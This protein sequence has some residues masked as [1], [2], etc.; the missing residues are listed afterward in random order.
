MTALTTGMR[1]AF[2]MGV[3]TGAML[4]AETF[5]AAGPEPFTIAILPDTQ[6]YAE[7][8]PAIF[9]SQ[10]QWIADNAVLEN[11][12]FVLHEG[13]IT[14]D[15][16]AGQWTNA[17][18]SLSVLD[19]M[20]P[21]ALALGNH[22]LGTNGSADTRDS[23]LFNT[24]FPVSR[25]SSLPT[26]GGV[27]EAGKLDNSFHLFT[28][29]GADWLVLALEFGPRDGVLAWANEV[30]SYFRSRR[31]IVVTHAYMYSDDTLHGSLPTH[32][33]NPHAYGVAGGPGGVND[34]V[35]MWDKFV[36]LH[37]NVRFVFNGH[38]L[39]DGVGT[40]VG[41]GAGGNKVY[42][43]LANYQTLPN[44]GNGYLRLVTFTPDTGQV[45]VRTYSP[46]L[47]QY[48]TTAANE[49]EFTGVDLGPLSPSGNMAPWVEVAGL[50]ALSLPADLAITG[51]LID[52][53]LPSGSVTVLWSK[54]SG[55]GAVVFGDERQ[56]GTTATFAQPGIYVLRLEAD[57]GSLSSSADLAVVVSL[58]GSLLDGLVGEWRFE[59]AAG[60]VALDSSGS[61]NDG[62]V[63]GASRVQGKTGS[64]LGLDGLDDYV[65]LS[66]VADD[67]TSGVTITAWIRAQAGYTSGTRKGIV[68]AVNTG[69]GGNVV[70][71]SIGDQTLPAND[72]EFMVYDGVSSAW[73]GVSD[74]VVADGTWHHV[75]YA[76]DGSTGRLYV[77]GLEKASHQVDYAFSPDDR[78]FL[79][80][81]LD[82]GTRGDFLEGTI[83]E[84][85]VYNR[86]L[87]MG[88]L[89]ALIS[90]VP[91]TVDAGADLSALPGAP[92][93]LDGTVSGGGPF[94]TGWM[95]LSGPGAVSFADPS[96]VDTMATF[97]AEGVYVLRLLAT[98]GRYVGSDDVRV[99]VTAARRDNGG[100]CSPSSHRGPRPR[101]GEG[102]LGVGLLVLLVASAVLGVPL[103]KRKTVLSAP[104]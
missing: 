60:S 55:P 70:L 45:S 74:T 73:E 66:S 82:G 31:V 83:D 13:D 29:G 49:F 56:L 86:A 36:R 2:A 80:Q 93:S 44:G 24:Y 71:L 77:D 62:S 50:A 91:P 10:T 72:D 57:D 40:L 33:W 41:T 6:V 100:G 63:V 51:T 22:D 52:D 103:K 85:R 32:K 88:E 84:V 8:F 67:V 23:T 89:Q 11:I 75:A 5:G 92:V 28:A 54:V 3:A 87:D 96:A 16:V 46:S 97:A 78:W 35:E 4:V 98:D 14:D 81:E 1:A 26:F 48:D 39:N 21:Y 61:G 7:S 99:T 104:A 42:Q 47:G 53:G 34:G 38:V 9:T 18:T 90:A 76:S 95:K 27:Y 102:A 19:G 59:E 37:E 20:V 15:N 58:A 30:C 64:G 68:A 69:S 101:E 79:G 12:V 17:N 65:E 94:T 43:M 25:F